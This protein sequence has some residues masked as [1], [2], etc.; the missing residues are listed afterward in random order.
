MS[1]TEE[2]MKKIDDHIFETEEK[3]SRA[4]ESIIY[5]I[6]VIKELEARLKEAEEVIDFYG[7]TKSWQSP[8][9]QGFSHESNSFNEEA[10][11]DMID[12]DDDGKVGGKRARAYQE[13]WGKNE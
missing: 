2:D 13:K 5:K 1:W 11:E 4:Q 10:L 6:K 9:N 12:N 7:N 8:S 3:L